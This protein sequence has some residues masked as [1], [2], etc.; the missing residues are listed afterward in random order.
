MP[1]SFLF[2][3]QAEKYISTYRKTGPHLCIRRYCGLIHSIEQRGEC[4]MLS[5]NSSPLYSWTGLQPFITRHNNGRKCS[6]HPPLPLPRRR[7]CSA[8]MEMDP[9]RKHRTT[10]SGNEYARWA[11]AQLASIKIAGS[12]LSICTNDS[13]VILILQHEMSPDPIVDPTHFSG[14]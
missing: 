12:M 11:A 5:N 6:L 9:T 13:F 1:D 10:Y 2:V 7:R 14:L 8:A 4:S 3:H